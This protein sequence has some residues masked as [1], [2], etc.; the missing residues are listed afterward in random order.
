MKDTIDEASAAGIGF[1]AAAGNHAGDN[2][3]YPSYPASY[4]SENVISVGANNHLGKSAY[5]SCYGK[6]KCRS[7]CPGCKHPQYHSR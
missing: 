4:E 6:T 7:I 5:F 2:D 1:V 3:T